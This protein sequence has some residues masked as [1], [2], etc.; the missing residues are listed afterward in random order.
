MWETKEIIEFDSPLVNIVISEATSIYTEKLGKFEEF[1]TL[2]GITFFITDFA[3][4]LFT[5]SHGLWFQ[6]H[7]ES[8]FQRFV[9]DLYMLKNRIVYFLILVFDHEVKIK[10]IL[11]TKT[12]VFTFETF[13][14]VYESS[15]E[16]VMDKSC[17]S[18]FFKSIEE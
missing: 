15:F 8:F 12:F 7:L 2:F 18:S 6:I 5:T 13:N 4:I 9:I 11:R 17:V 10:K 16:K 14:I 3:E 1:K